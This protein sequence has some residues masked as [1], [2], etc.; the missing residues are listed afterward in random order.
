M[1]NE[2]TRKQKAYNLFKE[3]YNCCQS[4]VLAFEDILPLDRKQLLAVSCGFGGGFGRTRNLCGAVSA[5]AI[6]M[7]LYLSHSDDPKHAKADMYKVL[8]D[9]VAKFKARN[10]SDNC[11]ELLKEVKNLTEGYMPQERDEEYYKM[12][13][14]IKFVLDSVEIIEEQLNS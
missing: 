14:C 2:I 12:R 9:M 1:P 4:V 3:G 5:Y 10:G 8:Q 11:G 6:V 13:P 7:G